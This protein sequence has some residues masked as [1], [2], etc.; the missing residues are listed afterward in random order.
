MNRE[1]YDIVAQILS[2]DTET[3]KKHSKELPELNAY[4]FW[5]PTRGGGAIIINDKGE[6]FAVGSSI[7]FEDH[8]RRFLEGNRN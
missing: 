4:Y 7:G 6:K 3:A 1:L 8:K 2:I 5:K